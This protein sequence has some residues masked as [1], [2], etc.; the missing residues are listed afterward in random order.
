M[1]NRIPSKLGCAALALAFFIVIRP[2][3]AQSFSEIYYFTG[4]D[5]AVPFGNLLLNQGILYGT[6]SGGGAFNAG[7]V[8]QFVIATEAETVLHSFA[9]GPADGADPIAGLIA[10]SNGNL[11]GV[12]YG[13]GASFFG[14][15]FEIHAAG[16]IT[17]LHSFE[18]PPAD[19]AG[20]SGTLVLSGGSF[21]GTTY[22]GG[23]GGSN[24][25]GTVFKLTA[26]GVYTTLRNFPP[27]GTFPRAGLVQESGHLYGAAYYGG[28]AFNAGTVFELTPGEPLYAFSGGEDGGHPMAS[29]I[30][31]GQG[32]LYGTA[33]D[34]GSGT[35]G[36]G[37]GVV[38]KL[39]VN[40]L[41]RTV[42]HIFTGTDGACPVGGL[43]RDSLGNLY[44]TTM[45]GGAVGY[46]TVFKLDTS[47]ALTTL[48]S[49]AGGPN[50]G[51]PVAGVVFDTDGNLWGVTTTG[52]FG[53]G[54]IFEIT[55]GT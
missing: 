35:L 22:A 6:T 11:Y 13:G 42:L 26:D 52:G 20:P 44:G 23:S 19:G 24:G 48:H 37:N 3:Q 29:L 43:L 47:G 5:G 38:F 9:G 25:S 51:N 53:Y 21:F 34:G 36:E 40:T 12:T 10:D 27:G 55:A 15:V 1:R 33:S 46:G 4:P 16:G 54:M 8:F 2:A 50:G 32:N 39:D 28:L 7:T 41:Q 30:G 18:G 49:F 31:D 14:T 45:L 17:L